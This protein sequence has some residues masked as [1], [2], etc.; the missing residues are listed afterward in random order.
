MTE[1][2]LAPHG[3]VDGATPVHLRSGFV[4]RDFK[5][6]AHDSSSPLRTYRATVRY[7]R[8]NTQ[9]EIVVRETSVTLPRFSIQDVPL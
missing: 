1:S 2:A 9:G 4:V 8:Q 3:W 7:S 5:T 6:A